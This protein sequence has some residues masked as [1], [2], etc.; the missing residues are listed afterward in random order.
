MRLA[1]ITPD[2]PAPETLLLS[3]PNTVGREKKPIHPTGFDDP[4]FY[5]L[6]KRDIKIQQKDNI[7]LRGLTGERGGQQMLACCFT[8]FL[9]LLS[10]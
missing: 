10:L 7:A 2:K 6:A 8:C 1:A 9:K 3:A 5:I 4:V